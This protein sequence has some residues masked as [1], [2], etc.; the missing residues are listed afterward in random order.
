[1]FETANFEYAYFSCIAWFFPVSR[2]DS[3]EGAST[4]IMLNFRMQYLGNLD[5]VHGE[6]GEHM[7]EIRGQRH[8]TAYSAPV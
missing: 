1:M 8:Y 2:Q 6:G 4:Y 7:L 3:S 5:D